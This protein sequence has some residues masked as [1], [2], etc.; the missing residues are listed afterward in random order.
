MNGEVVV[1]RFFFVTN[2]RHLAK[3]KKQGWRIQQRDF[4]E[5]LNKNPPYFEGK[6]KSNKSPDLDSVFH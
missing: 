4:W 6:K 5:F 1:V 3:Q 2:F